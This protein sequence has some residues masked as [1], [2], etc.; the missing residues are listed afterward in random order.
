MMRFAL[1]GV[2]CMTALLLGHPVD[3]KTIDGWLGQC[4]A[5]TALTCTEPTAPGYARQ[6]V[7][8]ATL[9]KGLTVNATPFTFGQAPLPVVA[10]R[11]IFDAPTGGHVLVV[12][13][14][15]APYTVPANGDQADVGGLRFTFAALATY[16]AAEAFTG[17]F[18]SGA[19][20]GA[21]PDGSTVTAGTNE[22]MTRGVLAANLG[23][24]DA[25]PVQVTE[26][27]GFTYQIPPSTST[28]DIQGAGTLA[29]G[30]VILPQ[31]PVSGQIERLLCDVTVT[32]LT[33]TPGAG[34]TFVG[35]APT[36]CGPNASHEFE[37]LA[38]NATWH[39][40]F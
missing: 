38:G 17:S 3:A 40:L 33:L 7:S 13:P 5:V 12:L 30:G 6:P 32:T 39:F 19:V 31:A 24:A 18:A 4:A 1:L 29:T 9:G 11:A 16:T 36:T 8:F 34:A 14:L 20:L 28:V 10:G 37:Y 27:T 2:I 26:A 35:T 21:T 22:T 25:L 15:A 23:S